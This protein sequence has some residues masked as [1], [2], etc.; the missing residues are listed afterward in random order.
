MSQAMAEFPKI[1]GTPTFRHEHIPTMVLCNRESKPELNFMR[2]GFIANAASL[3][4][5]CTRGALAVTKVMVLMI[6]TAVIVA[7][8]RK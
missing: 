5:E 8:H 4:S 3:G 6:A 2:E 1:V 7:G